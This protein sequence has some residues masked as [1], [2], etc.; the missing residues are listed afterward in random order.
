MSDPSF[1]RAICNYGTQKSKLHDFL[2]TYESEIVSHKQRF[3]SGVGKVAAKHVNTKKYIEAIK[4]LH[5]ERILTVEA[6]DLL[7][8]F[9][10]LVGSKNQSSKST[11][12][13]N[14]L[15]TNTPR[16][17]S[18]IYDVVESIRKEQAPPS[19][20]VGDYK[21][22]IRSKME[23][24]VH[25]PTRARVNYELRLI[26]PPGFE[27]IP[28]HQLRAQHIG[29][30]LNVGG[31]V[32]KITNVKP[33]LSVGVYRCEECGELQ[34]QHVESSQFTRKTDCESQSCR[35]AKRKGTLELSYRDSKFIK[36][37][38][39]R[40]QEMP[41]LVPPGSVP[42][43]LKVV[44]YGDL[45]KILRPGMAVILGGVYMPVVNTSWSH[46][47]ARDTNETIFE[48]H[49]V[50]NLQ[51]G[52]GSSDSKGD[53]ALG[54]ECD[55][56]IETSPN[57]YEQL[58][59]SLAPAI[60]GLGDVKKALLLQLVGGATE[61]V[62]EN[63]LKVRGDIHMLLM[64][65]P[66]IAKS[67]LLLRVC[68]VAPR[69]HFTCGKGASGVGLTASVVKDPITGEFTLEGGAIVLA[70]NGLCCVDEF[71]KMQE[72]DRTAIHEVMEQQTVSI[73]KA[74]LVATL[75]ARTTIL[76]AAN[77]IY[78]RYDLTKS[79]MANIGLPAALLS[80]FDI[81]FLLLDEGGNFDKDVQMA[82]HLLK[83][84]REQ[85]VANLETTDGTQFQPFSADVIRTIIGKAKTF[86]PKLT[87]PLADR[88]VDYYVKL[89][90]NERVE[91][92]G[93]EENTYTT[94]RTLF[95]LLRMSQALARLRFS[96]TIIEEDFEEALRLM[97]AS[98]DSV[99]RSKL[100]KRGSLL[101]LDRMREEALRVIREVA[102]TSSISS[103]RKSIGDGWVEF[104]E[105]VSCANK[106]GFV[107]GEVLEETIEGLV[108]SGAAQWDGPAK[109]L[110]M[111]INPP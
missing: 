20:S 51:Q 55:R 92:G 71:D 79:A 29:S 40:V 106:E 61:T 31:I 84:H 22:V 53:S 57:L 42:R 77:P 70:D 91:A 85:K 66:G 26:P 69:A 111:L 87:E 16:L 68:G 98:K 67:Q 96:D 107:S 89:R 62:G 24:C 32:S 13:I 63:S 64:G 9:D 3:G 18:L 108:A 54:A 46:P 35:T 72:S 25:I 19:A 38:E 30:L 39:A 47:K 88:I 36:R 73:S 12:V 60:H 6:Q 110:F 81:V 99:I 4:N 49:S 94:P 75:N 50:Q 41:A 8:Y 23:S 2:S 83:I 105:V 1:V 34:F 78:G 97:K 37:Q 65:D 86:Y 104:M 21:S 43:Q 44:L 27:K 93:L 52:Y 48:V 11:D 103:R 76:A 7:Q 90:S 102:K 5:T 59:E 45:T 15:L 74:G 17:L 58:A 80:R 14:T 33:M 101:Y 56:V 82:R 109:K 28:I 100:S 10:K 95:G